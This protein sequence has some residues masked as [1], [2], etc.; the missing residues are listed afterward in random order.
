MIK[1]LQPLQT[2]FFTAT[3][4]LGV[5]GCATEAERMAQQGYPPAYTLGYDDGCHSGKMAG[6][7]MFE[8]MKKDVR[9]YGADSQYK[10]GW[11]DGYESCEKQQ[12][13]S[14]R[15]MERSIEQQRLYQQT[16]P[17]KD[18]GQDAL[19]GVDTSGLKNL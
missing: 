17:T 2:T 15:A 8:H 18:I 9:R 1:D 16:H 6:G 11:D 13:A 10:Q 14:D 12:E 5:S 4:L 19:K 7:N 3:L